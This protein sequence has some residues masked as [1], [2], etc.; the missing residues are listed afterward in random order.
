[1]NTVIEV[2]NLDKESDKLDK[3]PN[4]NR[5]NFTLPQSIILIAKHNFEHHMLDFEAVLKN[6]IES[7]KT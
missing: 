1:M 7:F 5:F 3:N 6:I 4:F 2:I